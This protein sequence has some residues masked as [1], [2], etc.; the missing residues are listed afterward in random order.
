MGLLGNYFYFVLF[1]FKEPQR[2]KIFGKQFRKNFIGKKNQ[3]SG[4]YFTIRGGF[5]VQQLQQV[6]KLKL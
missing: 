6:L 5:K 2:K 1:P 3:L 4:F